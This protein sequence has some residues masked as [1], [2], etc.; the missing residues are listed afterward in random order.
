MV[1]KAYDELG[2]TDDFIFCAILVENEDLCKELV[3]MITGRRISTVLYAEG[4]RSIKKTRDGKGVR[5]DVYFED[6]ENVAYDIEMQVTSRNLSKRVRYY[7]GLMDLDVLN[8][9]D[10]YDKLKESYIIFICTFDEFKEGRH[11]YSFE[12]ICIEDPSIKLNDG[13]HKIFLCAGGEM[14]DCS[15]KMKDFLDYVAG[16]NTTGELTNRLR[17]EVE[18]VKKSDRWRAEYML[19]E[20]NYREKYKEGLEDGRKEGLE[21]GE[22]ERKAL[23]DKNSALEDKNVALEEEI[24][25]L[26]AQLAE[27][28]VV[29]EQ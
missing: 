18:R 17:E 27:S 21:Q 5:L 12:N 14:D 16:K 6:E 19:L 23:E 8:P 22:A 29:I 11:K 28:G 4:Q 15:E 10:E 9:G 2:F 1:C 20:L 13:T 3:E 24:V 25:R 26:K 7:Q